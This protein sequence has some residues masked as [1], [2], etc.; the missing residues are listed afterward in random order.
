MKNR[1]LKI[2]HKQKMM[3]IISKN[4]QYKI[5]L[6]IPFVMS[7]CGIKM[8]NRCLQEGVPR[9]AGVCRGEPVFVTFTY[10][11]FIEQFP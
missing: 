3:L 7:S 1:Q 6:L 11:A 5:I 8:D 4:W 9:L 10:K 2:K